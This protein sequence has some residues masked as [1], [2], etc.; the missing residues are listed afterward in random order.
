MNRL[1]ISLFIIFSTVYVHAQVDMTTHFMRSN[2]YSADENPAFPQPYNGY[3]G[4]PG[5]SS[6]SIGLE[7][8][9]L[10]YNSLF[11]KD[12]EGYPTT[13]TL[14]KLVDK[15]HKNNNWLNLSLNEE[16]IGFGFKAGPLFLSF[17]YRVKIEGFLK[18]SK[19]LIAF[20]V[21]GN[22]NYLG[23]DH[24]ADLNANIELNAFQEIGIGIQGNIT[25]KLSIGMRPK[26]LFGLANIK[27][28]NL[29]AQIFTDPETYEMRMN[30][31]VDIAAVSAFP[32]L[33]SVDG[34]SIDY[35]YDEWRNIFKNLGF[36]IDLGANY[37]INDHFG[38]GAS[39]NNI[40]FIHWR[41]PGL[42][43]TSNLSDQG[44]F[45]EDGNFFFDGLTVDQIINLIDNDAY[46]KSFIDTLKNYFPVK[47]DEHISGYK[48]LNPRFNL[49]GYYQ[50]NHMH[51][52][53]ALF[54]GTF[55][56]KSFYPRFMLAYSGRFGKVFELCVNYSIMPASY[57]NIGVGL[58]F[59]LWPV[60]LYLATD[61]IIGAV[62]P[63]SANT[64][65]AK[66]GLLIK[67]GNPL[68]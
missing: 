58:G 15:L 47:M 1:Y 24:P 22:M 19:D 20:P 30:Y 6:L 28:N 54:Q 46:R 37:T 38:V 11:K 34:S 18:F 62:T 50:I 63:L 49:E 55:I 29:Q 27:T 53:S 17:S 31:G 4:I 9:S 44:Q 67:W 65:N 51:R 66:L 32:T 2:P 59:N 35:A 68:K 39:V 10:H 14:D 26:L 36:A 56:G 40:G 60:Y 8:T 3:V 52:F 25:E 16:I 48:W 57:T 41:T 43:I 12:S 33:Y 42:K 7:N 23:E 5:L 13:I 64:V 21:K 61:N 45:Y